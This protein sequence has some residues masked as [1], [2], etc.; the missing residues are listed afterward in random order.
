MNGSVFPLKFAV[1]GT[2]VG[3]KAT[4]SKKPWMDAVAREASLALPKNWQPSEKELSLTIYDFPADPPQGDVDNIIKRIQDALNEV[5]YIDD[6]QVS[7]VVAQR[8]LPSDYEYQEVL[9]DLVAEALVNDPPFVYIRVST[10]PW[11]EAL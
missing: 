7:R 2:P 3:L 1:K 4:K 9:P 10:E 11:S 6:K 8:F 5:V